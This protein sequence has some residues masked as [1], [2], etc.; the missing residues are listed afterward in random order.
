MSVQKRDPPG[1]AR[2]LARGQLRCWKLR[3]T[4]STRFTYFSLFLQDS[5]HEEI[6]PCF[7]GA[8]EFIDQAIQDGGVVYVHCQH[9]GSS[10]IVL[11]YLM[12]RRGLSYEEA[13]SALRQ[14]LRLFPAAMTCPSVCHG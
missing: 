2:R 11:A 8:L 1:N 3:R 9:G 10:T 4:S 7:Y 14:N 5:L 13:R 12:W 6:L